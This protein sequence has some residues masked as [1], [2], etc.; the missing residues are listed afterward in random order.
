MTHLRTNV[1]TVRLDSIQNHTYC[2]LKNPPQCGTGS[3]H[4]RSR[5]AGEDQA[6]VYPCR[7]SRLFT[8]K[9]A[10]LL[11]IVQVKSV[12][13]W[14]VPQCGIS[15]LAGIKLRANRHNGLTGTTFFNPGPDRSP[16]LDIQKAMSVMVHRS[17]LYMNDTHQGRL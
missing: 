2:L 11:K 4:L 14:L 3:A 15:Q 16:T 5:Y 12:Y 8:G 6:L 7:R 13:L 9:G 17:D 1:S 10:V